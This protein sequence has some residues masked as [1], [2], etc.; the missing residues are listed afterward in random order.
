MIGL[1]VVLVVLTLAGWLNF[2]Q[3]EEKNTNLAAHQEEQDRRLL[4]GMNRAADLGSV[5]D[6]LS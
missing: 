1:I 5:V 6:Q 2:S 4:A 3:Q